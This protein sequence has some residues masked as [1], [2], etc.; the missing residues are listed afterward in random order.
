MGLLSLERKAS[1]CPYFRKGKPRHGSGRDFWWLGGVGWG[2][3]RGN[4]PPTPGPV[5]AL[6]PSSPQQ[7]ASPLPLPTLW[8]PTHNMTL[9]SP[10][11][12]GA[13]HLGKYL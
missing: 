12:P 8:S 6:S 2:R 3:F 13:G 9:P 5:S 7:G 10:N 11:R 4:P 1:G